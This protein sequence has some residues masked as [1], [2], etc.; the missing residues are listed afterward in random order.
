ML[1]KQRKVLFVCCSVRHVHV[2]VAPSPRF[3][4]VIVCAVNRK[5]EDFVVSL[6]DVGGAVALVHIQVDHEDR[7]GRRAV[8]RHGGHRRDANVV[9]DA[10]AFAPVAEGVVRAPGRVPRH[11]KAREDGVKRRERASR[12]R[13]V[14]RDRLC[15]P[16]EAYRPVLLGRQL[17]AEDAVHVG[18]AVHQLERLARHERRPLKGDLPPQ[19][20]VLKELL[21]NQP[22][23]LHREPVLV[24]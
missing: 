3:E 24:R 4:G 16:G 19:R 8:V 22:I 6:E 2:Q 11:G 5:G 21:P 9:E 18:R 12:A 13:P 20:R 7:D 1:L 10:E 17:A 14:P 23:L 15:G